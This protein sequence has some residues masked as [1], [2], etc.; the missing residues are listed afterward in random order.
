MKKRNSK[1]IPVYKQKDRPVDLRVEDL[2]SRMTLREKV[3]QMASSAVVEWVTEPDELRVLID[4]KFQWKRAKKLADRCIAGFSE[5]VRFVPPTEGVRRVNELQKHCLKKTRLGIPLLIMDEA[6]HGCCAAQSTIFPQAIGWASTWDTDFVVRM[7]QSIGKEA[8][9]RGINQVFSPILDVTH[10]PRWGRTEETLGEDPHLV[11]RLG[12]AFI[13]GLQGHPSGKYS[14][15][16]TMKHFGIHNSPENGCNVGPTNASERTV[17]DI[18][19]RPFEAGVKDGGTL[20]VMSAYSEWDGVPASASRWLQTDILR[21]EWG[22]DGFVVS[23]YGSV[24]MLADR[25]AIASDKTRAAQL[26]VQAGVDVETPSLNCFRGLIKSVEDGEFPVELIDRSVRRILKAKFRMGLFENP[27]ADK[28]MVMKLLDSKEHRGLALEV[29]RKSIILLKND[30]IL[31]IRKTARSIAVIGPNA[32]AVRIGNYGS[33]GRRVVTA[34][35]GIKA[36]ALKSV[37]VSYSKGCEIYGGEGKSGFPAAIEAARNADIAVLVMGEVSDWGSKD[38]NPVSGEGYDSNSLALGGYQL[39]LIQEIFKVQKNV[40]V[41][42]YNGR[43]LALPW[44]KENIPAMIEAWYPGEEGGTALGEILFGK[45]NP[46]GRLP[47]T[48]PASVGQL[49]VYYNHKPTARG[50]SKKPGTFDKAGRDYV[51]G[52]TEPLFPFGFGLSYTKFAYSKL[53]VSPSRIRPNSRVL[54]SVEVRNAGKVAGEE[55]VQLYVRDVL[56]SVTRPVKELRGFRRIFLKPGQK[57]KVEFVLGPDDLSFT[58]LEGRRLVEPG[59]FEVMVGG[60]SVDLARTKFEIVGEGAV[61]PKSKAGKSRL[62]LDQ[63]GWQR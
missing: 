56:A 63:M 22:F 39:E 35:E 24:A 6:L 34:L 51:F 12:T 49:P 61:L 2:L 7:A 4:G 46:S 59:V 23:D 58:G 43:P 32:A 21:K 20:S 41:V 40:V 11:A 1:V 30:G 45:I 9:S 10:D 8:R 18:Y 25:H 3:Y 31:P 55:V 50:Y 16:T 29:A 14:V 57:R 47:I 5:I 60:N 19:L 48:V 44:V 27:Y 36:Q 52:T 62:S 13:R 17:R 37:K 15:M 33:S 42:L 38:P 28:K 53:A 26:A 54:V